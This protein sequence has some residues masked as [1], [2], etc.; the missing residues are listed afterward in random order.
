MTLTLSGENSTSDAWWAAFAAYLK[1][2]PTLLDAGN[3]MYWF[4]VNAGYPELIFTPWLAPGM[5][6]AELQNLTAPL[7]EKWTGLGFNV[8]PVYDEHSGFLSAYN[9]GFPQEAVGSNTTKSASRLVPR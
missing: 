7:L 9:A 1:Y 6:A 5:T 8:T 4:L 2:V 3:Y